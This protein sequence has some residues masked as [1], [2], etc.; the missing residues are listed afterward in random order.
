[1]IA[2]VA[3]STGWT[4]E[5]VGNNVDLIRLASLTKAWEHSPPM[6]VSL[7]HICIGLGI[8]EPSKT[9][10]PPSK[11]KDNAQQIEELLSV[12]PC[13]RPAGMDSKNMTQDEI[14]RAAERLM[15]GQE[16]K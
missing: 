16:L 8:H 2:H 6:H 11:P 9:K 14:N 10:P 1:M 3:I 12:F 13:N 7:H 5:Y 4:W 15:F